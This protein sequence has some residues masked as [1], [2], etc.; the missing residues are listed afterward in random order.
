M[1]REWKG[2]KTANSQNEGKEQQ[3][4]YFYREKGWKTDI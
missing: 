2:L 4:L 3:N 1:S